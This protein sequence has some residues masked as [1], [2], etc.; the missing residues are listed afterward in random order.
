MSQVPCIAP[1]ICKYVCAAVVFQARIFVLLSTLLNGG[2]LGLF[3]S[4]A[5]C[6]DSAKAELGALHLQFAIS[7]LSTYDLPVVPWRLW[8]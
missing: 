1:D 8:T 2:S 5:R 3:G 4:K 6:T 7:Y